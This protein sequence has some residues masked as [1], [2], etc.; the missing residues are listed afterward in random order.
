MF[1]VS[2][3][4]FSSKNDSDERLSIDLPE[5]D[6]ERADDRQDIGSHVPACWPSIVLAIV[7]GA[8]Q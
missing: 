2:K 4:I 8:D 6:V 1:L 7:S 5:H 3:T